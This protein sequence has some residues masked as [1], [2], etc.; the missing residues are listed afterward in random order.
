MSDVSPRTERLLTLLADGQWH[1]GE[2]LGAAL[3]VSRAAISK[4]LKQL[5]AVELPLESVVGRGYRLKTPLDLLSKERV[6]A[7]MQPDAAALL[8]DFALH[9]Q[10]ASTNALLMEQQRQGQIH[11]QLC[12]AEQQSAGRGRRG[13]VWHSPFAQNLYFSLGWHFQSGIAAIEGLSLAVGVALCEALADIGINQPRLKWPNDVLAEGKKLAGVLI[14][15]AGDADGECSVVLG[16]GMN[17][18]MQAGQDIDQP[19][20]SLSALGSRCDRSTVLAALLDRLLPLMDSYEALG[21]KYYQ[22]RWNSLN[23]FA[24]THVQL[25]S[26]SQTV[27]GLMLGVDNDGALLLECDAQARRFIGGEL[28]LRPGRAQTKHAGA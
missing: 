21:F 9:T 6:V 5:A 11:A 3:G 8:K 25:L 20:T 23:A 28:S 24:G 22:Q 13:R 2:E 15:L 17:V 14:E 26:P 10:L 19:W 12:V 1:S 16:I 7:A 4:Q 27:N 18:A